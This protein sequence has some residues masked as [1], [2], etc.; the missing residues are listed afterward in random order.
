MRS[1]VSLPLIFL[2][3]STVANP[4][5]GEVDDANLFRDDSDPLFKDDPAGLSTDFYPPLT[6]MDQAFLTND[7]NSK[8]FHDGW[9]DDSAEF[10]A[11]ADGSFC[12][13]DG[14]EIQ[15]VGRRMMRTRDEHSSCSSSGQNVNKL[16]L[17]NLWNVLDNKEPSV[18][19]GSSKEEVTPIAPGTPPEED[20]CP[21]DLPNHLCCVKP[22]PDSLATMGGITFYYRM[23]PCVVSMYSPVQC[24]CNKAPI[25]CSFVFS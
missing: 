11:G 20:E 17:P 22:S 16:Q 13:A 4:L 6:T 21:P 8:F 3:R 15:T 25:F 7:E 9:T 12:A 5:P 19:P 24:I 14:E 18:N 1:F 23:S 10:L 2:L